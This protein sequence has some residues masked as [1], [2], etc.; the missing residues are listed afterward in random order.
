MLDQNGLRK[1]KIDT[2]DL[3]YHLLLLLLPLLLIALLF[4]VTSPAGELPWLQWGG[5]SIIY[6]LAYS[7]GYFVHQGRLGRLWQHLEQVLG[8]NEATF[9]L[10]HLSSQYET[11]HAFLNALLGKAVAMVDGAEMG[12]II[13]VEP[14]SNKLHFES[15]LGLDLAKLQQ[16]NMTLEQSFEYR[17]TDGRCNR[18][19]VVNDM[20]KIN[21]QSSLSAEDQALLL[22]AASIPIRATLSSPIHI[23]G[24]LYAMLNLDSSLLACFST[25][26]RDLVAIL[27]REAANA[28]ALYQKSRQIHQLANFDCL[29]GL[30]NRKYF[31]EQ[32]QKWQP[33]TKLE[34]M[35]VLLDMDNL[36][37]INDNLGHGAGDF[38][39]KRLA[40]ELKRS[41]P[42]PALVSR[43][44]GD[45]FVLLCYGS[46]NWLRERLQQA[47]ARLA[48][49]E[50]AVYFSAG[51]APFNGDMEYSLKLADN[52]MYRQKRARKGGLE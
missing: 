44:G 34:S 19:V 36:K 18:V 22:S 45:E 48:A 28:I 33:K 32:A 31:E 52:Q 5:V 29:T 1:Q 9:E 30:A 3:R 50:V 26:D 47:E 27:T 43:F 11:E 24:Q 21:A 17:L 13:L 25:Y 14:G 20:R 23:D 2:L 42:P 15:A 6:F 49:D 39:L 4:W 7:L 38:A 41:C 10:V 46:E 40:T 51:I 12:S 8:I 16:L 35:L 37:K